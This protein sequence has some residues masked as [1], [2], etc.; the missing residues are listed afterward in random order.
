MFQSVVEEISWLKGKIEQNPGSM[1]Y[2]RLADRYLQMDEIENAEILVKKKL[3]IRENPTAHLILAKCYVKSS[4]FDEASRE[5]KNVLSVEPG[6]LMAHKMDCDLKKQIGFLTDVQSGYKNI[7][8]IDPF[9]T[10]T[11]KLLDLN[12][13]SADE[14]Y[15][16]LIGPPSEQNIEEEENIELAPNLVDS[17]S[18]ILDVIDEETSSDTEA[19]VEF[20]KDLSGDLVGPDLDENISDDYKDQLLTDA[21]TD[22]DSGDK[23]LSELDDDDA[24]DSSQRDEELNAGI[25]NGS[26]IEGDFED[27]I[28]GPLIEEEHSAQSKFDDFPTDEEQPV[29]GKFDEFST[30]IITKSQESFDTSAINEDAILPDIDDELEADIEKEDLDEEESRFS[31]ILDDIFAPTINEEERREEETRSTLEK[32]AVEDTVPIEPKAEEEE[33]LEEL[34]VDDPGP[35]TEVEDKESIEEV[36]PLSKEPDFEEFNPFDDADTPIITNSEEIQDTEFEPIE[37]DGEQETEDQFVDFLSTVDTDTPV[38]D[39]KEDNNVEQSSA[40]VPPTNDLANEMPD[41]EE[42][43]TVEPGPVKEE[44]AK[45]KFVTPTLG[46]IYAAQGQYTKAINVFEILLDKH[47]DN[48]WYVSKLEDLREKYKKQKEN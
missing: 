39:S 32:A 31:E 48:E 33:V 6:N 29:Q 37:L 19:E 27:S 18:D 23:S 46:E 7:L 26:D 5:L 17:R 35:I 21:E 25:I 12:T 24:F 8:L 4:R 16:S 9:D 36:S 15:E 41:I 2:A 1:L 40:I 42:P 22:I 11:K 14:S 10:D 47:P 30:P 45:E 3:Q 44:K 20:A 43:E 34:L 28:A 38:A 13:E